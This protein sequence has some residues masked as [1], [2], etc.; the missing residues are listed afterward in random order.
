MKSFFDCGGVS[1]D[2]VAAACGGKLISKEKSYITGVER[3]SRQ[4]KNGD[5]FIAIKGERVDGHDYVAKAFEK[6]ASAALV[7]YIPEGVCGNF[8]V[9]SDTV[10][11]LG[12]FASAYKDAIAPVTCGV[13]GS[14]GKTTV[15]QFVYSVLSRAYNTCKTEGNFNNEIGLPLSLLSLTSKHTAAVFELGMSARGEIEYLSNLCKPDIAVITN[16]GTSHIEH[17][18]SREEIRNAKMEIVSGMKKDGKLILNGDEPLL[19]G[20]D[21][22]IYV[23]LKNPDSDYR[24]T[25]IRSDENGTVFDLVT[26]TGIEEDI[27]IS[28]YGETLALDAA[29]ALAVGDVAE[30]SRSEIRLGL[31]SYEPTGMRQRIRDFRGITFIDDYYNAAPESMKSSIGVLKLTSDRNGGASV[32]VLG[33]MRELGAH[34][35]ELHRQVG[36]AVIENGITTLITFGEYASEIANGAL[37]AG[38]S[39]ENVHVF[40]DLENVSAVSAAIMKL[41]KPGDTVLFKAS[42]AVAMERIGECIDQEF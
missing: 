9:V 6:G 39:K 21:G 30:I 38:M 4:V 17:L 20:V 41:A 42:R 8:I 5:L 14:V 32:A 27:R 23:S 12:K 31:A 25:N 15:K 13:T 10:K 29:L 2:E 16:I 35:A 3:D 22:A 1:V 19:S 26:P 18:G 7:E 40:M 34:S 24:V 37:E 36:R 11:A 33:D 28:T